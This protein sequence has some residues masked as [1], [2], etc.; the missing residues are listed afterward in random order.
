MTYLCNL[1]VTSRRHNDALD[2]ASCY[3]NFLSSCQPGHNDIHFTKHYDTSKS[4]APS[5]RTRLGGSGTLTNVSVYFTQFLNQWNQY[6]GTSGTKSTIRSAKSFVSQDSL[7]RIQGR[8]FRN[9]DSCVCIFCTILIPEEQLLRN[10]HH[11]NKSYSL[12]PLAS[13]IAVGRNLSDSRQSLLPAI[14]I[15]PQPT[16]LFMPC[17]GVGP[18]WLHHMI[19]PCGDC[20]KEKW[21]QRQFHNLDWALARHERR[22]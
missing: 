20:D 21:H 17:F 18:F 6:S 12:V 2:N 9:F 19:L 4:A 1:A 11:V 16:F 14:R 3:P 22:T 15:V 13:S 10:L 5:E 7:K 8:G